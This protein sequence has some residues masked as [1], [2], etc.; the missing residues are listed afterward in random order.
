M[1]SFEGKGRERVV[2]EGLEKGYGCEFC[3]FACLSWQMTS[4]Q[5]SITA[6]SNARDE[7]HDGT[8][9]KRECKVMK[10]RADVVIKKATDI[11]E[12]GY[13]AG[14]ANILPMPKPTHLLASICRNP[15]PIP[16]S[17]PETQKPSVLVTSFV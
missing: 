10:G 7:A 2:C 13:L 15:M 9:S 4:T 5:A 6:A 3:R 1:R 12:E 11:A 14:A 16:H 17:C 8:R